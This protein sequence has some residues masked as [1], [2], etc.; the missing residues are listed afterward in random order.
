MLLT[1]NTFAKYTQLLDNK[2]ATVKPRTNT[3]YLVKTY[4]HISLHPAIYPTKYAIYD[5]SLFGRAPTGRAIWPYLSWRS[6]GI[7]TVS[8]VSAPRKD[9]CRLS[10]AQT[11]RH[12]TQPGESSSVTCAAAGRRG[13][14]AT[15]RLYCKSERMPVSNRNV[16]PYFPTFGI[17]MR[18]VYTR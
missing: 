11:P 15:R 13:V 1:T 12:I 9:T 3:S 14:R 8:H 16:L 10:L 6:R 18:S 4:E 2:P 5:T 17:N 7:V